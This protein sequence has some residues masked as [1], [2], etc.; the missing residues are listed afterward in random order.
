MTLP[1]IRVS[2]NRRF[3]MTESGEPFFW[4]G[5]TAWELF[6]RLNVK[7]AE[8]YLDVRRQQGFNFIQ[9]VALAELDGLHTPNAQGH[10]PLLGDDPTRPN[11]FYFRHVDAI[12]RTAASKELYIG[13]L[14]TWG[15]K[16]HA[17]MWGVGPVIFN[18][19]NAYLY[20]RFLGERYR[21]D[22]NIVWI[23]GGDR[24]AAGYEDLWT[25]MAQGI[26]EGAG[27]K[28]FFTYH[29]MGGTSSSAVLHN[30]DW[31]DMNMLQ[32]G[33]TLTDAPNWD[34]IRAD[35]E[36]TP[37]KP[38][39][40]GEPNYEHHP[41]DPYLRPWKPEYGRFTEYDV[42]KQAYR[43]VFAGACGHT[44][45]SHSVWQ[46]WSPKHAPTT[47]PSPAWDEAIYGP[48]AQQ[49]VHLK[50]LMLSR[51]YFTRI[52]AP[53]ML[54]DAPITSLP[55]DPED[56]INAMRAAHPVA[57]RDSEGRYG[58]VYFPLAGQ[59]LRVDLRLL[60]DNVRAAWFD[61]RSG[62]SHPLGTHPREIVTFVSPIA[63]PD[64]V[65]TLDA[66]QP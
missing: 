49:M 46:M 28:P 50:N 41:V 60:R 9:A 24:P 59:S 39:L 30:F 57:T 14:P 48:G 16:V 54:P 20:G 29:P 25:A 38:V 11:E 2:S 58:L 8:H 51:P 43:A 23:L 31:L 62:A 5:D 65:L 52:P 18:V 13:L 1:R 63:G 3:L 22:T 7:E 33:H 15:D 40:D 27:F 19:G 66:E 34:M 64:W 35:Y 12:I 26:T 55:V 21:N 37:I 17:Q 44:Y 61:P 45:G 32:S 4:L 56:R 53:D 42:R 47:F 10:V 36:R 6:H